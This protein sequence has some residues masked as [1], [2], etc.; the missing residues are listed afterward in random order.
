ML[1]LGLAAAGALLLVLHEITFFSHPAPL[2]VL[3]VLSVVGWVLFNS[4]KINRAKALVGA[5]SERRVAKVLKSLGPVGLLNSALLGAGGDADHIVVGPWLCVVETKTGRGVVR[6]NGQQMCA[7]NK[8]IPGD[9]VTQ[10][11]RQAAALRQIAGEYVEA[12]VCV[13]DMTNAPY[14]VGNTKV[15]SLNDLPEVIHS[16]SRPLNPARASQ[17]YE[18]LAALNLSAVPMG[19]LV[20]V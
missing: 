16:L 10:V 8:T 20:V 3:L 13:V 17:L 2:V 11:R 19:A 15:C 14:S 18:H 4:A 1:I 5:Q 12:I 6:Y 9:P 7:G